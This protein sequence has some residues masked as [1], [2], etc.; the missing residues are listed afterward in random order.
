MIEV[1]EIK[2][3]TTEDIVTLLLNEKEQPFEI[4]VPKSTQLFA[5]T[6]EDIATDYAMLAFAGQKLDEVADEFSYDYV[7]PIN[8][9]SVLFEIKTNDI[10]QLSE[11]ILFIS[12]GYNNDPEGEEIYYLDEVYDYLEKIKTGDTIPVCLDFIDDYQEYY[13]QADNDE[14]SENS[15]D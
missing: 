9:D 11:I 10:K 3:L 4:Y 2:N 1:Q 8:H 6:N 12:N 15:D 14:D 7:S 13:E 5:S